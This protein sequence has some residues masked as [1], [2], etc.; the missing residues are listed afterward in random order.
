MTVTTSGA[1]FKRYLSDE[2]EWA[3]DAYCDGESIAINSIPRG[4]QWSADEIE[5]G[6][7]VALTGGL[8]RV[9]MESHFKRWVKKQN[10]RTIIVTCAESQQV[11]V[12][13]AIKLAGGRTEK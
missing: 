8:V 1:E 13:A 11:V 5:D 9:A 7:V 10:T 2:A 6:D 12:L 3:D 4:D